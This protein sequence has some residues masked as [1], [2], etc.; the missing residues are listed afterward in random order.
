MATS[1]AS[2]VSTTTAVASAAT[3]TSAIAGTATTKPSKGVA[4]PAFPLFHN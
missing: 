4:V 3:A 1:A 2:E